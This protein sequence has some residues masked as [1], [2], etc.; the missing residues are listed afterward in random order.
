MRIQNNF[1]N[2]PNF[3]IKVP[4]RTALEAASGR[5]FDDG[6]IANP[7]QMKLL[8]KLGNI[9][10]MKLYSGEVVEAL[11]G[12]RNGIRKQYP[13][14]ELAVDRIHNKCDS[15]DRTFLPEDERKFKQIMKNAIDEEIQKLG[16][17]HIDIKPF[18]LK[19]LGLDKYE[20]L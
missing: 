15:F 10:P 18:S 4:V 11:R 8:A 14:L 7:R 13:E 19:D 16:K 1:N 20:N 5:F 3:G 17:K 9:E 2:N 6:R 12:M